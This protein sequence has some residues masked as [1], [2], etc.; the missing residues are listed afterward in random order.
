MNVRGV[1][2]EVVLALL[3][4]MIRARTLEDRL[5]ILYKQSR[6]R[7]RLISGRGQEAICVGAAAALDTNE[8]ICP[9]HRDLGAHLWRGTTP[10]AVLLHYF[11]RADGPSRGRDGDIHMGEWSRRV[12]PMVSH[13]PDSW[14]IAVGIGFSSTLSGTPRAV[15]A[16]CGDGAT[17]TGLWHESLNIASVFRTPNVFVVENNQYAYSTPTSRQ[18]RVE[19]LSD[20]A[21]AY[22]IPGESVDGNDVIAV[23]QAATTAV[24]RARANNGPTL[25]EA[26]TM[27]IDGHAV[28]DPADYVPRELLEE[29]RRRDPIERLIEEL[30]PDHA[31]RT[32]LESMR[33]RAGQEVE[34]A[35]A[36]AEEASLP[37]PSELLDGVY[38]SDQ[39]A[40]LALG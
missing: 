31:N 21:A 7:G 8:V 15:L 6:I 1:S 26:I 10:V 30:V 37:N 5:H 33:T 16:F 12:F 32:D 35:V 4:T 36:E 25:I 39:S 13:L 2:L 3:E 18:F 27:R 29:W 19:R 40:K 17:S 34:R 9:V 38:A 22:G 14:P 11:G 23:Y 20:R 24:E 28:H